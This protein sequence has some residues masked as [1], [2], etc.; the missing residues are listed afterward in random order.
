MEDNLEVNAMTNFNY[1]SPTEFIFGAG[2][3]AEVGALLKKYNARNVLVIYGT[4][5]AKASGLLGR[6][7]ASIQKENISISEMGGVSANPHLSFAR[8]AI[9]FC[10]KNNID[11]LL[12]VGGGSVIDT[13]K[14][15]AVGVA[16]E[17]GQDLWDDLYDGKIMKEK[18]V[19]KIADRVLPYATILTHAA[20][21]SEGNDGA[22]LVNDE[23]PD[24]HKS[25]LH[26]GRYM[27]P[28][29]T[30]MNPELTYSASTYQTAAGVSDIM[31][32][33]FER[34]FT[35]V[36]EVELNDSLCEAL[37]RTVMR[38]ARLVHADPQNYEGRSDIMWA[39]MLAH[40]DILS[41][42]RIPDMGIH[43]MELQISGRLDT[44]HGAGLA[45]LFPAYMRYS[46]KHN[47]YRVAR[48][49][50]ELFGVTNADPHK[51]ALEGIQQLVDFYTSLGLPKTLRELGVKEEM[52]MD[53]AKNAIG[54]V[55]G[56]LGNYMG[57]TIED[58]YNI[59]KSCY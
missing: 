2:T 10:Q 59:Y 39:G 7:L 44:A 17:E 31:A 3:E 34:Y 47:A 38:A 30:I 49:M 15:V 57:F 40:N 9:D 28:V 16:L 36:T 19:N 20:V 4:H 37:L 27:R 26:G 12:A 42:G 1:C 46:L 14:S 43:P 45:V 50:R 8:S 22:V 58:C 23:I 18:E 53:M 54:L 55:G 32:H 48:L 56:K 25:V 24:R 33:I 52:L 41:C 11:F 35:N 13:C 29:F 5:S 6:V 51:A 21:G